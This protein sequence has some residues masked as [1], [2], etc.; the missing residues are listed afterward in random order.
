MSLDNSPS[1]DQFS[2]GLPDRLPPDA[3]TRKQR[4]RLIIAGLAVVAVLFGALNFFSSAPGTILRGVGTLQ[5]R[6]TDSR[7]N[8]LPQAE[9][10]WVPAGGSTLTAD[11]GTFILNKIPAGENYLVAGYKGTGSELVVDLQ[12]GKTQDVGTIVISL[13]VTPEAE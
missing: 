12:A 1:L 4:L 11:D 6:V 9:I 3:S 8:P 5:G 2:S 13:V 7:G 10:Y